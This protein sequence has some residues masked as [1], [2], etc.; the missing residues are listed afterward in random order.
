[1]DFILLLV[2]VVIGGWIV[3]TIFE[4]IMPQ[5]VKSMVGDSIR[6]LLKGK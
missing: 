2:L 3:I 6:F 1:M 5:A 4:K